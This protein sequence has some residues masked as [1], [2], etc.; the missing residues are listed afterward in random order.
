LRS[1]KRSKSNGGRRYTYFYYRCSQNDRH[2]FEGCS[3]SRFASATKLEGQVWNF[4]R[5]IML[6][7]EELCSDLERA[8]ELER[9]TRRGDP[10]VEVKHWLEKLSELNEER[11]GFLRLAAKGRI[12][13]EELDEEL[14]ALEETRQTAERELATLRQHEK[15]LEEMERDRVAVLDHYAALAPEALDF[16]TS[17][18]RHQLY[19]MLRLE[20]RLAKSGDLELEMAGVPVDSL[21]EGSSIKEFTS[22]SA[23]TGARS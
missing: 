13:D 17:E 2:G 12:A 7:P 14:A 9:N 4:V 5:S 19:K 8:I 6:D 16:L 3:N 15:R 10:E 22:E 23:R 18:E 21:G 20:V 1:R 11:R